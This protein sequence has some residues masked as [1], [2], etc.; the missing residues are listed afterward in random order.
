MKTQDKVIGAW[1]RKTN[2]LWNGQWKGSKHGS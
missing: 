1:G 2:I